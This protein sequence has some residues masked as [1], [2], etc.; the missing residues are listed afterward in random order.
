MEQ[1][2]RVVVTDFDVSLPNLVWLMVKF[3]IAAIPA[4]IILSFVAMLVAIA[5]MVVGSSMGM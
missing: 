4:L 5:V 1:P 2:T 3:A